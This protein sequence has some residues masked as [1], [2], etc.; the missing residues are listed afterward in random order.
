MSL[1]PDEMRRGQEEIDAVVGHNR[2]PMFADQASLPY[3]S[4]IAK[5][6]AR[7]QTV[8]GQG[9]FCTVSFSSWD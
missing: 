2:L 1:Y 8:A 5:E 3:V 9:M 7:W 6:V 4:A